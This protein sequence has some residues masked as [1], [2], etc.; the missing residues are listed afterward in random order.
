MTAGLT[1]QARSL[2]QN[3]LLTRKFSSAV[4][5]KFH[6]ETIAAAFQSVLNASWNS[7]ISAKSGREL[8]EGS[9]LEVDILPLQLYK[10]NSFGESFVDEGSANSFFPFFS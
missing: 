7:P 4:K 10:L 1:T 8:S 2:E 6:G 3:L 9:D 5:E